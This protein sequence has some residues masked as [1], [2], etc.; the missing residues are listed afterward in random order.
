MN[1]EKRIFSVFLILQTRVYLR[2]YFRLF[3]DGPKEP[4]LKLAGAGIASFTTRTVKL[5]VNR[6]Q[7]RKER[8]PWPITM[9][10]SAPSFIPGDFI[11]GCCRLPEPSAFLESW[12]L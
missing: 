2:P 1:A 8:L 11:P 12:P 4:D 3:S 7:L 5:L 10:T 9:K 6:D